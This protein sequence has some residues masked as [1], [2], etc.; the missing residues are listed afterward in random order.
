MTRTRAS[1][2]IEFF[3]RVSAGWTV[4]IHAIRPSPYQSAISDRHRYGKP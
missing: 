4:E 3:D 2:W 1:T